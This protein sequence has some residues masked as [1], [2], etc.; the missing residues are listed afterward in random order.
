[1]YMKGFFRHKHDIIMQ[2]PLEA[3]VG[4]PTNTKNLVKI[5]PPQGPTL[6]KNICFGIQKERISQTNNSGDFTRA[7][8][9]SPD[10]VLCT[11]ECMMVLAMK[12]IT[13]MWHQGWVNHC[14][15]AWVN[16]NLDM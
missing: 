9:R 10:E 2:E 4:I 12:G 3:H 16:K 15:G 11:P 13:H 14:L 6:N 7:F 8:H 1:M 5:R